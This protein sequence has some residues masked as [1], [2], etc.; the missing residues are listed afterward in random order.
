MAPSAAIASTD[1]LTLQEVTV[2]A[3]KQGSDVQRHALSAT[4][5][6]RA[7]IER[8][9]VSGAKTAAD[10]IPNIFIPDYG[11]RMT[12]T[13]YVRGLGTRIDQP[14]MG[15]NIDNVPIICKE[16]YDFNLMDI[17]KVEMLRGP[18][19]TLFGRN[20]MAG[21]MNIYTLSP[22]NYSGTR[23]LLEYGSHNAYQ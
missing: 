17:A 6:G 7:A 8:N 18:Q 21:V 15:L 1:T 14:T 2:S 9:A 19:S 16:N 3:I 22:L 4:D 10:L 12:S 23:A 13:I 5:I 11:S 20:T